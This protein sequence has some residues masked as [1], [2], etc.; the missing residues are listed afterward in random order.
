MGNEDGVFLMTTT[1]PIR[2]DASQSTATVFPYIPTGAQYT[3]SLILFGT[4]NGA[5][6]SGEVRTFDSTGTPMFLVLQ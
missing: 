6:T 5:G 3:T 2:E 1:G 4:A